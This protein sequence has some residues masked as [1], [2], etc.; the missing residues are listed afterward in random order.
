MLKPKFDRSQ[1]LA[2]ALQRW[3]PATGVEESQGNPF[4]ALPGVQEQ[5]QIPT[6]PGLTYRGWINP[7]RSTTY[8]AA[9]STTVPTVILPGNLRRSY[10]LLQ[11]LGPG[12]I[13]VNFGADAAVNTC[14][15][16]VTTQFY[17]QVGGGGYDYATQLSRPATFVTP[18]YVSAIADAA[19]TF[20]VVTEGLWN[21]NQ[22][23]A[24]LYERGP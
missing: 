21:Y 10:L 18:G 15:F 2:R 1:V 3:R 11:N 5:M 13:W 24:A 20:V 17:E 14:H 12:N 22:E 16:F 7:Y 23:E 8:L 6:D 9:L 19:S 4:Y